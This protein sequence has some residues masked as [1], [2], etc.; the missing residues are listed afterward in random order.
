[1][2]V[3]ALLSVIAG[4]FLLA[5]GGTSA[6]AQDQP[7]SGTPGP[8]DLAVAVRAN[9]THAR[10]NKPVFFT[11]TVR[12]VG[13][14]SQT[15]ATVTLTLRG[16]LGHPRLVA[17]PPDTVIQTCAPGS[18]STSI[19]CT[20]TWVQPMCRASLHALSCKYSYY[21]LAPA[22][23][24]ANSL[25]IVVRAFTGKARQES[26]LASVSGAAGDPNPA[27]NRAVQVVR[28]KSPPARPADGALRAAPGA[29]GSRRGPRRSSSA[30]WF[31]ACLIGQLDWRL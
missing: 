1:M 4:L 19:G 3:R 30:L 15:G 23:P 2:G 16:G 21:Q 5:A 29:C 9:V 25:E 6:W 26:A 31:A 13:G 14:Q 28:V 17:R 10:P 8:A 24:D 7:P 18:S 20:S 11:V 27:N 12:N 22:G